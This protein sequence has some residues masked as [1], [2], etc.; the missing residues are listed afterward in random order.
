MDDD[1]TL[2]HANDTRGE[3][4]VKEEPIL[5][6][7]HNVIEHLGIKLYQ[8][9]PTNVLAELV[10]NSWDAYARNCRIEIGE[11]NAF[12]SVSDDGFGM[13]Y[14]EL[15][16]NYLIIGLSKTGQG[17]NRTLIDKKYDRIKNNPEGYPDRKPMGRKGIGKLAPFGVAKLIDVIT[18]SRENGQNSSMVTW[19]Q[20]DLD[21]ITIQNGNAENKEYRPNVIIKNMPYDGSALINK[22]NDEKNLN[23]IKEYKNIIKNFE[24]K[25]E[26]SG[27]IVIMGKLTIRKSL[28]VDN[29]TESVGR[30]L[31]ATIEREDF[32]VYV[33][34]VISEKTVCLENA[35]P[36]FMLRIPD[37]GKTIEHVGGK[38]VS[39][40]VGFVE[41]ADWPQ[42]QAGVGV[43]AH[44][45]IAQARPFTFGSKGREIFTR[46]MFGVVEADWIDELEKIDFISTDRSSLDWEM[47]ELKPLNY[48]GEA[49]VL[50]WT[51]KYKENKPPKDK[52]EIKRLLNKSSVG[53]L[54][55]SEEDSITE[56]MTEIFPSISK[57]ED[58]RIEVLN[59][60]SNAWTHE[61]MRKVIK[62]LWESLQKEDIGKR[63][64][65]TVS[66]LNDYLIPESLSLAVTFSQRTYGLSLLY[67]MVHNAKE[68]DMQKLIETFP[69]IL[70]S[71]LELLSADKSLLRVE[72]NAEKSGFL[73]RRKKIEPSERGATDNQRPDF[74][75]L[76]SGG[77]KP[78]VVVELKNPQEDLTIENR[79]QIIDYLTW[80]EERYD[81]GEI[82]GL[83]IGKNPNN[84]E[85]QDKRLSI[86]SWTEILT[87]SRSGH[88]TLL[89]SMI[90]NA[91]PSDK[92]LAD[93]KLF[94]GSETWELL[95][96]MS[97]HDYELKKLMDE[98][99]A[100]AKDIKAPQR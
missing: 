37:K 88:L 3:N 92:R 35:L 43:Y 39:Y 81:N 40:W 21:G 48:W 46:Y 73:A 55:E 96:K 28:S 50:E 22:F 10:A 66:K 30:R 16:N 24:E 63:F 49:K 29:I 60:V 7:S 86:K 34:D 80:L 95:N 90:R 4:A 47:E 91:D 82:T 13:T 67:D 51:K 31:L 5:R 23:V 15:I 54:T 69:W 38:E 12:I 59:A 2:A 61:P 83:L 27:T 98:F 41:K 85:P 58:T 89:A 20:L 62:I 19:V 75:F 79:T 78:M 6:Y 53:K 18:V 36:K 97:E 64:S 45:K 76:T 32:N 70:G 68:T 71:N 94:G 77:C 99:N 17:D 93:I 33:K 11:G 87:E 72:E 14:N 9:K 56:L 84:M 74:V 65:D 42:D 57:D 25:T 8:N 52:K 100:I 26:I 1:V 44:G